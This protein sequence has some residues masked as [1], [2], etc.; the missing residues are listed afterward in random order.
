MGF[1]SS[2]SIPEFIDPHS[3]PKSVSTP[4]RPLSLYRPLRESHLPQGVD[5][6]HFGY[7]W[8]QI[9]NSDA[10]SLRLVGSAEQSPRIEQRKM[11]GQRNHQTEAR[12]LK[13]IGPAK[14]NKNTRRSSDTRLGSTR[15]E[16]ESSLPVVSHNRDPGHGAQPASKKSAEDVK[17]WCRTC[18]ACPTRNV[19][20]ANGVRTHADPSRWVPLQRKMYEENH[21][22]ERECGNSY[23]LIVCDYSTKYQR[24]LPCLTW[25]R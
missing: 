15:Y 24:P 7:P 8:N 12:C 10:K 19:P 18:E 9:G 13:F 3:T 23:L 20:Q 2:Y 16:L 6:D 17:N 11:N 1:Q 21:L 4:I 25:K 14:A 22:K 5:I